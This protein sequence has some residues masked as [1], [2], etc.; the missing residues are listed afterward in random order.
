VIAAW[1]EQQQPSPWRLA[2][3]VKSLLEPGQELI[4]ENGEKVQAVRLPRPTIGDWIKG[5]PT[6]KKLVMPESRDQF[7]TLVLVLGAE[8][9]VSDWYSRYQAAV[10]EKSQAVSTRKR[11]PPD[12]PRPELRARPGRAPKVV[13]AIGGVAAGTTLVVTLI[14]S[15]NARTPAESPGTVTP[16]VTSMAPSRSPST[17]RPSTPPPHPEADGPLCAYV[18]DTTAGIY[19]AP[20]AME[21][22]IRWKRETDRVVV[23]TSPPAPPG[24][25][26]VFT[27]KDAPGYLWMQERQLGPIHRCKSHPPGS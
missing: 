11:R 1:V 9:D 3:D 23:L 14:D 20:R 26:V 21:Q 10:E 24:W 13:V 12:P 8:H 4:L 7:F 5:W 25:V 2:E 6:P 19:R 17:P 15:G 22:A 16:S 18:R 27:P